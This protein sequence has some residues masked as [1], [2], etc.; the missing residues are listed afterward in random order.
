[1]I[2]TEEWR[3]A[4]ER[5]LD[6]LKPGAVAEYLLD[7]HSIVIVAT[8]ESGIHTG[9][10]RFF[11]CCIDCRELLHEATTGPLGRVDQHLAHRS[12]NPSP[13]LDREAE[14]D[15]RY[16]RATLVNIALELGRPPHENNA[17]I[18][19]EVQ[20]LKEQLKKPIDMILWCPM[21]HA[22]HIDEGDFATQSHKTHACQSCGAVW[23][24]AS[25]PTRGVRFLP[26]Y[27]DK[28][29]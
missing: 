23:S 29:T 11:V 6:K 14:I 21:C 12:N 27:K 2:F 10:G 25:V 9:R 7:G 1:M 20:A 15:A 26:G 17:N 22:R 19:V 28:P 5:D 8:S 18:I 3:H 13:K 16:D 4:V 24:Q